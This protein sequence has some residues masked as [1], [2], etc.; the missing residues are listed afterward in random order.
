MQSPEEKMLKKYENMNERNP[1]YSVS[2][3][4]AAKLT[5][6]HSHDFDE[7]GTHRRKIPPKDVKQIKDRYTKLSQPF[8]E[9]K[10]SLVLAE[11][12]QITEEDWN[13]S[14]FKLLVMFTALKEFYGNKQLIEDYLYIDVSFMF[15]Y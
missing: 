10:N 4:E 6:T 14:T 13:N 2:S 3:E 9:K 1:V 8:K 5:Q 7:T 12:C 15:V 11:I